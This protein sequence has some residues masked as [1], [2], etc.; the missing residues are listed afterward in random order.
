MTQL[1]LPGLIRDPDTRVIVTCG[2]GGVGKTT[3][4]A[5]MAMLGAEAGRRTVVL[6]IDPARR[7]AQSMGLTELDNT[8]REVKGVDNGQLFA[9]MLD[10][11]RTFDDVVLEHSTPE[12]A[13]Q[14]FANPFYQSLSSSFA[15]T[16]EYM[17]MEK[18]GQL[19]AAEEWDLIVVDTPPSRSALDFLD[20]PNRLGR[21]LDGRMIRLLTAPARAGGKAYLKVVTAGVGVLARVF[22][23]VIGNELLHDLSSFVAAL[24]SMFGGFRERAQHTYELLKTPGTAFVVVAAP[25]PDALREASY[26]VERLNAERMPLAGLVVNRV[27]R[28][29]VK[30][31]P[32]SAVRADAAAETLAATSGSDDPAAALAETALRVHAEI[33]SAAEHDARMTKRFSTA[34][35]QVPVIAVRALAADVHDL[36]GLRQIGDLLAPTAG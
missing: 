10:M 11:K 29:E 28:T 13:E 6:T 33:A 3:I 22:T 35:P 23:K 15:G 31:P 9:M 34:H 27:R 36:D 8:P 20:A 17:A 14:I 19:V 7:L 25:E 24:E 4:A 16:Q 5:A 30:N 21:F 32:F 2:S 1:D 12:R 26:F 18:L